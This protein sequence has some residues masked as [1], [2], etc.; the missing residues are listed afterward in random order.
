MYVNSGMYKLMCHD[1]GKSFVGP[2][3]HTLKTSH[4]FHVSE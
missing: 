1:I 4:M 2:V 3:G